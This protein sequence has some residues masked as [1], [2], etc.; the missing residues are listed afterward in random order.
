MYIRLEFF[1]ILKKLTD[2]VSTILSVICNKIL[3]N[4]YIITRY[5]LKY[6]KYITYILTFSLT[7]SKHVLNSLKL[8][9]NF[10]SRCTL[11]SNYS[12]FSE[13]SLKIHLIFIKS[14]KNNYLNPIFKIHILL[15]INRLFVED[16][17]I[18]FRIY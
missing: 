15:M 9:V 3:I 2:I 13:G 10:Y 12:S 16:F 6:I 4:N 1:N 18:F 11:S 17:L 8:S 7:L 14:I 5:I